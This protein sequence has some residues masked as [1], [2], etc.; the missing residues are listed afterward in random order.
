MPIAMENQRN[1]ALDLLRGLTIALMIVVNNPGDWKQMFQVLK[2]AEWDGFLGADI[3]FPLF[4]FVAGF[5]AAMKIERLEFQEMVNHPLKFYYVPL[6]RRAAILFAIGL[7]L[8]GWPFG[9]LPAME[10]HLWRAPSSHSYD[11]RVWGV[12]QRI[13]LCVLFGGLILRNVKSPQRLT[14]VLIV[15]AALYEIGMR[16]PRIATNYGTF[17]QSFALQDNFA[18]FVDTSLLPASML[19][20][21][22]GIPFDPEGLFTTITAL[23]TFLIGALCYRLR[24][25]PASPYSPL[26]GGESSVQSCS[27]PYQGGVARSVGVVRWFAAALAALGILLAFIEPVNK[28][29][30]TLP[31]TLIT[32]AMGVILLN[33][34]ERLPLSECGWGMRLLRPIRYMGMNPLLIYVLSGIVAK[35]VALTKTASGLSLK[36][37]LFNSI[38]VLPISG[39]FAS[40]LYALLFLALL[41]TLAY[42]MRRLPLHA[43]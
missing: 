30:W 20:K 26:A 38:Q 17:G 43:R 4:L 32:G 31:Y 14:I 28:N 5:A 10:F 24:P 3:V 12:L 16:L 39:H 40:L 37:V 9:L 36:A 41:T 7:F 27:P 8:N 34:L 1:H 33:F 29:L 11:L 35:T 22:Q 25:I 2:H 6:L 13:A 19:Y 18:R 15:L 42:F 21:V 23:V